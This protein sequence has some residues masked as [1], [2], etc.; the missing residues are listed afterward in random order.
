[1]NKQVLPWLIAI[2]ALGLGGTAGYYSVIG[3]S[4]LFAGEATAVIIM[5][6]F[7][8]ASKLTLATLLHSYWDKLN[9]LIRTYYIIALIILSLIT[10]VGIYGMLSN[11]YQKTY[12]QLTI[13]ENQKEY[14]Q[15]KINFYQK[16]L[17][18]YDI[19]LDR[20]SNNISTLSN[21]KSSTTQ[22][23]DN[24]VIGGVRSVVSTTELK[25]AQQRIAVE[26][27]NKKQTSLQRQIVSDSLQNLQISLLEL[28]NNSEVAGELGPLKYIS[29]LTGVHM[30]KIINW[31][32][33]IIIF[34]F[35][36]LA[37]SL[38]IAANFA[39][40]QQLPP[41]SRNYPLSPSNPPSSSPSSPSLPN[42]P[43]EDFDSLDLNKDGEVD[44]DEIQLAKEKV[45][46]LEDRFN[47]SSISGW[48]R[49]K[50]QNE[51]NTLKTQ[52]SKYPSLEEDEVK[53]Y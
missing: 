35:D 29:N 47:S 31:L 33:L 44:Y 40:S 42:S 34:V 52:I 12:S 45:K 4:K 25:M 10:S 26:E 6:S 39:F 3:L 24:S 49:N 2:C 20:I 16:D 28:D 46:L 21:A 50:I 1:M 48:R 13:V 38:V 43:S 8:E 14:I 27:E 15:Q 17:D 9:K 30:D 36:P 18:R 53:I 22:I 32:L 41:L 51:I 19:E 11:G 7:L 23:K 37:I 5:A